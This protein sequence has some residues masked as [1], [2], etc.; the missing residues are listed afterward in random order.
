M[1]PCCQ[2]T[3]LVGLNGPKGSHSHAWLHW[4]P[5][6]GDCLATWLVWVLHSTVVS[7]GS[8]TSYMAADSQERKV[9]LPVL[10]STRPQTVSLLLHSI[11]QSQS[12]GQVRLMGERKQTLL[13][14]ERNSIELWPLQ[15]V[16][17]TNRFLRFP[18]FVLFFI[19][20][21]CHN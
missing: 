9:E 13:L 11:G 10:L 17:Y 5:L 12:E 7:Q 4:T 6:H 20:S 16:N 21:Y 14:E 8:W 15:Q 19:I 3:N 2:V 1:S 18:C